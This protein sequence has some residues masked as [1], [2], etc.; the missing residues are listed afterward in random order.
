MD[1]PNGP[2]PLVLDNPGPLPDPGDHLGRSAGDHQPR[3]ES[4]G[5]TRDKDE[6][7]DHDSA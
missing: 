6:P 2:C 3:A 1:T 4:S 5:D 7:G